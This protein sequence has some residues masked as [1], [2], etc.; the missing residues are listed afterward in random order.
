MT[1]RSWVTICLIQC[2]CPSSQQMHCLTNLPLQIMSCPLLIHPTP[3]TG[4]F[5]MVGQWLGPQAFNQISNQSS[6]VAMT[7]MVLSTL[8][9]SEQPMAWHQA[10]W[11]H[12]GLATWLPTLVPALTPRMAHPLHSLPLQ[13]AMFFHQRLL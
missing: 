1:P 6:L 12:L 5:P 2:Q 10:G 9:W 4:S 8:S 13:Q 3:T 7:S 11:I